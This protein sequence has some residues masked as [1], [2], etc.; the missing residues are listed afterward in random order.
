MA[1][2]F[3][4]TFL[5]AVT[6]LMTTPSGL[7]NL[8][9]T[10]GLSWGSPTQAVDDMVKH[11]CGSLGVATVQQPNVAKYELHHVYAGNKVQGYVLVVYFHNGDIEYHAQHV[12]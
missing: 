1:M 10:V 8:P 2:I 4:G 7:I 12:Y 5:G 6:H 9:C 3:S 11:F